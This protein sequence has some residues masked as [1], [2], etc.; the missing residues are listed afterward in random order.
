MAPARSQVNSAAFP[1]AAPP[2]ERLTSNGRLAGILP[3]LSDVFPTQ[4]RCHL[5]QITAVLRLNHDGIS[6]EP[7]YT[8]REGSYTPITIDPT[9]CLMKRRHR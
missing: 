3:S 9:T 7:C 5:D 1:V 6:V 2:R 4:S 8:G